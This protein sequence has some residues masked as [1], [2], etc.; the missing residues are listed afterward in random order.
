[1]Y[2]HVILLQNAENI[3][4]WDKVCEKNVAQT[5]SLG[6]SLFYIINASLTWLMR[7][8]ISIT[9]VNKYFHCII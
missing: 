2:S 6:W 1:M 5:W 7:N 9:S 3:P 8:L 4:K